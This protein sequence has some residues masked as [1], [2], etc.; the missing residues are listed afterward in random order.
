MGPPPPAP[1]GPSTNSYA[2]RSEHLRQTVENANNEYNANSAMTAS[3]GL[4]RQQPMYST[5]AQQQ[6]H[7]QQPNQQPNQ[8]HP[9]MGMQQ[10]QPYQ[11]QHQQQHQQQQQQQQQ[12][13]QDQLQK[14]QQHQQNQQQ[15]NHANPGAPNGPTN[16][17]GVNH[18]SLNSSH[19]NGFSFSASNGNAQNGTPPLLTQRPVE[20]Q[21]PL[22]DPSKFKPSHGVITVTDPILV[23]APGVFAGPPHWTYY[24]NV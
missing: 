6:P 7:Q 10:R 17:P 2:A 14:Q 8:H 19:P 23:Q 20:D 16:G 12:F 3:A 13:H 24:I 11:Q 15:P 9:N 5:A 18:Y 4:A 1:T 21:P 22:Y